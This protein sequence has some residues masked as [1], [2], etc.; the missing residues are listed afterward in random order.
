ME[1]RLFAPGLHWMGSFLSGR[2]VFSLFGLFELSHDFGIVKGAAGIL[3]SKKGKN[4][5]VCFEG[6]LSEIV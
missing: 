5:P 1:G 6:C 4:G 3:G 2:E